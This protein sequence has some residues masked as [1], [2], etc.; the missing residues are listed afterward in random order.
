MTT[1]TKTQLPH[2]ADAEPLAEVQLQSFHDTYKQILPD[3]Y[4]DKMDKED[5]KDT[6]VDR[7]QDPDKHLVVAKVK[8]AVIGYGYFTEQ[9]MPELPY[10]AEIIEFYVHPDF[11]GQGIGKKLFRHIVKILSGMA[12]HSF[13]VW[14]LAANRNACRFYEDMGGQKLIEGGIHWPGIKGKTFNAA[15][16]YWTNAR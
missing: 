16:Y 2:M 8:D 7:I 9:R 13:N 5:I 3:S 12:H 10:S 4:L 1:E 14:V 15:C 6:F 11:H